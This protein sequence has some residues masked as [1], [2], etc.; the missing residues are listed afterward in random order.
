MLVLCEERIY[1]ELESSSGHSYVLRKTNQ[2]SSSSSS[3]A[4]TSTSSLGRDLWEVAHAVIS[5]RRVCGRMQ[6]S[7]AARFGGALL[8]Q[9][10]RTLQK[11][12]KASPSEVGT[13]EADDPNVMIDSGT[14]R[15]SRAPIRRRS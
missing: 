15:K 8:L 6:A 10:V 2:P 9:S 7:L 13:E 11:P 5:G 1:K 4:N 14:I 3:T 12:A